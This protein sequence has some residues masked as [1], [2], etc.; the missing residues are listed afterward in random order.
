M[1]AAVHGRPTGAVGDDDLAHAERRRVAQHLR[2]LVGELQHPDVPQQVTVE[3]AVEL[4][5]PD[6]RRADEPLAVE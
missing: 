1:P 3:V 5:R 4:E 6:P 2:L